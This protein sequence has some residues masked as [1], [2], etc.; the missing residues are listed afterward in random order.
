MAYRYLRTLN[1]NAVIASDDVGDEVILLGRGIALRCARS[2]G[3]VIWPELIERVFTLEREG[4]RAYYEQ[5]VA[6]VPFELLQLVA[7]VASDAGRR[8]GFDLQGRLTLTL[9]DHVAI[10]LER[11]RAGET[12][13]NPL[14]DEIRLFYP[15]EYQV[16]LDSVR[17]L[18]ERL[19]TSF[20]VNEAAYIALHYINALPSSS[21][22]SMKSVMRALSLCVEQ[23]ETFYQTHLDR[24]SPYYTRLITHLKF[25]LNRVFGER[26][27]TARTEGAPGAE[28]AVGSVLLSIRELDPRAWSCAQTIGAQLESNYAIRVSDEEEAYLALH[29]ALLLGHEERS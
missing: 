26:G 25:F 2:R 11:D 3:A 10:A 12:L 17:L 29:V 5:L 6:G 27:E 19:G 4:D 1:N 21:Q 14:L 23:I 8:L 20:D 16:A 15:T 22:G 13:P 24:S 9:L 7:E 28:G 18:N